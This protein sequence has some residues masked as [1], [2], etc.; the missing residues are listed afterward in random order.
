MRNFAIA[1]CLVLAAC[2]SPAGHGPSAGVSATAVPGPAA[3]R[4]SIPAQGV[5]VP[6]YS[7]LLPADLERQPTE[8]T[9]FTGGGMLFQ[10]GLNWDL[11][12]CAPEHSQNCRRRIIAGREADTVTVDISMPGSIHNRRSLYLF[13]S[14]EGGRTFIDMACA[15]AAC[16]R[17]DAIM[18]SIE[19]TC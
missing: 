17:A 12:T 16:A 7:I 9:L 10:F 8:D 2:Q 1:A 18:Q 13:T 15:R 19:F 6:G 4:V 14:S 3:R 5:G 11:P